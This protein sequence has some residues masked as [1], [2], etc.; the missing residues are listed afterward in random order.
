MAEQV[1]QREISQKEFDNMMFNKI[2]EMN[3]VQIT[4]YD[5]SKRVEQLVWQDDISYIEAI[6]VVTD[7]FEI[8]PE[9]IKQYITEDLMYKLHNSAC[10]LKLLKDNRKTIDLF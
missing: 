7:E 6:A 10:E 9:D 1:N 2:I 5:F 3:V 4:Q 8:Q